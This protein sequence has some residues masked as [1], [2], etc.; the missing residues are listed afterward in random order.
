MREVLMPFYVP[1]VSME[2]RVLHQLDT[3]DVIT[4][5]RYDIVNLYLQILQNLFEPYDFARYNSLSYVF[6]LNAR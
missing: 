6:G 3:I 2:E 5:D 4:I 1:G